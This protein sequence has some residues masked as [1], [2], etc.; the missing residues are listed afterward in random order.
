MEPAGVEIE[1]KFLVDALPDGLEA[2][3][4][5]RI[6]QGYVAIGADGVEV[7]VRRRAGTSTL[8]VKSAPGERRIE[9]EIP[10]DDRRFASLWSLSE[11]RRIGKTRHLVPLGSGLTAELDV[12][13]GPLEGLLTVEVE[14]PSLAA[15]AA[16]VPPPWVGR[17]V[18]GDPRYANQ[19]LALHGPP[20]TNR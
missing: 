6:E 1:R 8:T 20:A 15:S 16:F 10:I 17:E 14:F 12:Y 9:E 5:D 4:A 3:R 2:T 19:S 18:T 13:D 11:G 7:R